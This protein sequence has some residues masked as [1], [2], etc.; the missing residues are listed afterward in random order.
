MM[1]HMTPQ[2]RQYILAA[3]AAVAIVGAFLLL[4]A[5]PPAS[6]A[7]AL[8]VG[9]RGV[10]LAAYQQLTTGMSY[11]R[12]VGILGAPG[13]E[14]SRSEMGGM[15]TV[16]YSWQGQGDLGANMNAMFQNGSLVT[17]AQFGL[18]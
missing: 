13:V 3:G 5:D 7:V 17:K 12:A 1:A 10:S 6:P 4:R 11:E 9:Q 16:M 2:T 15:V 8:L 18:K 14:N